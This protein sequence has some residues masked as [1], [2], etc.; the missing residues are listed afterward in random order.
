M[1]LLYFRLF[2]F[3]ALPLGNAREFLLPGCFQFRCLRSSRK[4]AAKRTCI[5]KRKRSDNILSL[6]SL[7]SSTGPIRCHSELSRSAL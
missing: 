6:A 5:K 4:K 1:A 2:L 7:K 3:C